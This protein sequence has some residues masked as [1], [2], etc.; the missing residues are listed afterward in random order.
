MDRPTD[1]DG[2]GS[3]AFALTPPR[4]NTPI[5]ATT[6]AERVKR[7]RVATSTRRDRMIPKPI[8]V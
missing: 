2:E 5:S 3:A 6:I 8:Y 4:L 7:S 1:G